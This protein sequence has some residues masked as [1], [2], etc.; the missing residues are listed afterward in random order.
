[1]LCDTCTNRRY[2]ENEERQ[3]CIANDYDRYDD[4]GSAYSSNPHDPDIDSVRTIFETMIGHTTERGSKSLFNTCLTIH[5]MID[6]TLG[7]MLLMN[8]IHA[9]ENC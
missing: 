7:D 2:C 6:K 5:S 4:D 3:M 8:C 9:I 1:M